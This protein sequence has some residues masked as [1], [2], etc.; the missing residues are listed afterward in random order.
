MIA[1]FD[2]NIVI[3][4]LNGIEQARTEIAQYKRAYISPITW[5]EAQVKAPEGMEAATRAVIDNYFQRL[6]LDETTLAEG[7]ALRRA[8]RLKLPDALILA[9][10]RVNGW[11]LV[12]RN[13][14]DFPAS[15]LGVR[16]PYELLVK[17]ESQT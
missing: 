4:F 5:I 10:A 1:V 11:L 17:Q 8:L 16:V 12:S 2:S 9:S 6:E 3:D 13:T 7:L 14:K 15:M